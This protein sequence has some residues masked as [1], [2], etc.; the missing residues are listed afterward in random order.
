[1]SCGVPGRRRQHPVSL[2]RV[3][4]S[5]G[6]PLERATGRP[7][8]RGH[9][10]RTAFAL[11]VGLVLGV[12]LGAASVTAVEHLRANRDAGSSSVPSAAAGQS[13]A[14]APAPG[15]PATPLAAAASPAGAVAAQPS[16]A[17]VVPAVRALFDRRATALSEGDRA[18]WL[19]PLAA[20]STALRAQ[21]SAVFDR[22]RRLPLAGYRWRVGDVRVTGAHTWL[23]QAVLAYRVADDGR[24]VTRRQY[25]SVGRTAAGWQLLSDAAGSTERDLWDLGDIRVVRSR[26]CVLVAAAA[27]ASQL[28]G[29]AATVDRAAA[30]VDQVWGT[31]WPR[32]VVVLL[33]ASLDQMAVL[34]GRSSTAG[35]SQLAAVTT[36]ELTP[37]ATG[38]GTGTA[39][40][41]VLNPDGLA[42][43]SADVRAVVLSHEL[44][45]VATRADQR[46][47]PPTWLAEGFAD[48]VS[49]RAANVAPVA[50]AEAALDQVRSHGP[51]PALPTDAAFDATSAQVQPA[52]AQAWVAV[53]LIADRY[54]AASP[55]RFYR[56]AETIG[57]AE[58][59]AA[60]TGADQ[61]AF[62]RLWRQRLVQLAG[63]G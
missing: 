60:V 39:D 7:R 41:V 40:R 52:Y 1:M 4:R 30:T 24:D 16:P 6:G 54:G 23:V 12:V 61:A 62:T 29:L 31:A 36:G 25:W 48:W 21:Q 15:G 5:P 17:E 53:D 38:T 11:A 44:T 49:Y 34:L 20:S 63:G 28:A 27:E 47:S 43:F 10:E 57:L 58:A 26:R 37:P 18:G 22:L 35:L 42:T 32:T 14:P 50:I 8:R 13:R 56:L 59:F 46:V 33:P 19:G 9:R 55:A 51:P 3:S 2:G 45:H